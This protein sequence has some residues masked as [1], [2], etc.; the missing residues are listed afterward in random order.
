MM[1]LLR[2]T[3]FRFTGALW[4]EILCLSVSLMCE[5]HC[6]QGCVWNAV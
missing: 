1:E 5:E 4:L 2:G 3:D 6:H